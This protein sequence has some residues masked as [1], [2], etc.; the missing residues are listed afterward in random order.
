MDKN[1]LA[2]SLV[3]TTVILAAITMVF[4]L[5]LKGCE[6]QRRVDL[7]RTKQGMVWNPG[8]EGHWVVP[9]PAR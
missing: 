6:T 4:V 8:V 2:D 1:R 3:V 9:T 7:E 5:C